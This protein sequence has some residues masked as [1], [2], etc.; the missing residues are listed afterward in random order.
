[1]REGSALK[2]CVL[3]EG[4]HYNYYYTKVIRSLDHLFSLVSIYLF[5]N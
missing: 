2:K 4:R 1:M 3:G 5:S